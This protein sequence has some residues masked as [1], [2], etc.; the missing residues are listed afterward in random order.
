MC[1]YSHELKRRGGAAVGG[2]DSGG[3]CGK[4]CPRTLP[5]PLSPS[6]EPVQ[7]QV[8]G[9]LQKRKEEEY[10]SIFFSTTIFRSHPFPLG[11]WWIRA[12]SYARAIDH[13]A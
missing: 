3:G 7:V 11:L 10:S 8:K 13:A 9:E 5:L 4:T 6:Q 2:G 1:L 12:E